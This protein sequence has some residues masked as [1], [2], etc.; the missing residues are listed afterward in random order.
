MTWTAIHTIGWGSARAVV[1]E[2]DA[3]AVGLIAR[4]FVVA[5]HCCADRDLSTDRP[6]GHRELAGQRFRMPRIHTY[7]DEINIRPARLRHS[8]RDGTIEQ[9]R[10]IR[11]RSRGGA[12]TKTIEGCY[13]IDDDR[14]ECQR[15]PRARDS[16]PDEA[17][18]RQSLTRIA[19]T[20]DHSD[21]VCAFPIHASA[22]GLRESQRSSSATQGQC[23]DRR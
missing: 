19:H 8:R 14:L 11:S 15:D 16:C 17:V 9:Q 1:P 7:R 3:V 6:V 20:R 2:E 18:L 13:C 23:V 12:P 10:D 22:L 5:A 4:L 21:W